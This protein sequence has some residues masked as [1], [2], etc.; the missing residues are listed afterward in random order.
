M[1]AEKAPSL[2]LTH[3]TYTHKVVQGLFLAETNLCTT[4]TRM[5]SAEKVD[6]LDYCIGQ[7][8]VD[9][10][11]PV[12][13]HMQLSAGSMFSHSNQTLALSLHPVLIASKSLF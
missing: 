7:R 9:A 13:S 4:G 1:Q 12:S 6:R 11:Q 8:L 2:T 3:T 5:S 10:G